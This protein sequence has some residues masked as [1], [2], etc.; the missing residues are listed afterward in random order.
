MTNV[1]KNA[2]SSVLSPFWRRPSWLQVAALCVRGEGKQR[3]VL[4]ITSRDTGRWV[5]PKGW[6]IDGMNAGEAA[7][8]EAWEEAGVKTTASNHSQIGSY[9]Y[10]KRLD[11]GLEI[12]VNVQ[13]YSAEDV[14][15]VDEFPEADERT[16]KWFS[17][18]E[19]ANL[20]HEPELRDLLRQI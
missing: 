10:S 12:P 19:A 9:T 1:F 15:L 2:L 3:Q 18:K 16:R 8:Q 5:L 11:A 6:P 7:L 17:P 4:L 14:K 20:V 13:V